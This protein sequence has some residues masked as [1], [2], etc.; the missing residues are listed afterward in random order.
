MH[1]EAYNSSH[2]QCFPS[3]TSTR[4]SDHKHATEN[5][6]TTQRKTTTLVVGWSLQWV[7]LYLLLCEHHKVNH[8]SRIM[9]TYHC[10]GN[11]AHAAGTMTVRLQGGGEDR[12]T[13]L[14]SYGLS[15]SSS[16]S[17]SFTH[18]A[19]HLHFVSLSGHLNY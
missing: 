3:S 16:T 17:S 7:V 9:F 12:E 14:L 2:F 13:Q 4:L 1:F 19:D 5:E 6:T 11:N 18:P 15:V 10:C 8:F